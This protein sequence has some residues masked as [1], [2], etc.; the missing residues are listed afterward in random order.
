MRNLFIQIAFALAVLTAASSCSS[1][2]EPE[3]KG[4]ENVQ[5]AK[6][7]M[8]ESTVSM[9]LVWFNPN[10]SKLKLKWAMGDA[11]VEGDSLGKFTVD[12]AINIHPKADFRLPVKLKMSMSQLMKKSPTLLLNKEVLVKITGLARV[13]RSGIF[14]RY[15]ISYEGKQDLRKLLKF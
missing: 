9:D 4:I 2:K 15:P 5:M 12:T 1:I 8:Y 10:N 7:G 13:G 14:I 11:W 6:M 3:F